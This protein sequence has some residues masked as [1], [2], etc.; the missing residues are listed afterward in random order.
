MNLILSAAFLGIILSTNAISQPLKETG[1]RT[2][3]RFYIKVHAG[4]GLFA[5][6]SYKLDSYQVSGSA[7]SH[8]TLFSGDKNG[9]GSGLR[10]GGEIGY[11]VNG[12]LNVGIDAEY[13]KGTTLKSSYVDASN[14]IT[15]SSTKINYNVMA[16]IPHLV[17]KAK[18][19]TDY[20][21]YNRLGIL[22]SMPSKMKGVGYYSK[23]DPDV[24][25]NYPAFGSRPAGQ[26]VMSSMSEG[27]GIS[28]HE[29]PISLGLNE[30]LGCQF[31]I[32]NNIRIFAEAFANFSALYPKSQHSESNGYSRSTEKVTSNN[33]TTIT[34]NDVWGNSTTD[35]TYKK[36]GQELIESISSAT[37]SQVVTAPNTTIYTTIVNQ[38]DKV[39]TL[40]DP[41]HMKAIGISIGLIYKVGYKR[42]KAE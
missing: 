21:L 19:S 8:T 7:S 14:G 33:K 35:Y 41:V 31:N 3:K 12:F 10:L 25:T 9:I 6:G 13:L 29:I 20:C 32:C 16:I 23:T 42:V 39:T 5:P 28:H 2:Q 30:A 15:I 17:F 1:N 38:I 37:Q 26:T 4:Y 11:I 27:S 40:S 18:L 34:Y 24:V 36:K 22:L